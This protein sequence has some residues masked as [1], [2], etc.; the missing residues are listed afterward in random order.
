MLPPF[1]LSMSQPKFRTRLVLFIL[2][3]GSIQCHAQVTP[4]P[5]QAPST[6]KMSDLLQQIFRDQDLKTDPNKD[7]QRAREVERQLATNPSLRDEIKLRLTLASFELRAGDSQVAID[8]LLKVRSLAETHG[9]ILAPA[10]KKQI[11][12][13]LAIA[14]MRLGEQENCVHYHGQESCLFPVRGSGVHQLTRGMEGAVRELTDALQE[15]PADLKSRWLLNIAYITLG[16][17]PQ[18]VP[19][20]WLIP[21]GTFDSDYD[22][23]RSKMLLPKPAFSEWAT[24][25]ASSWKTSMATACST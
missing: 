3:L 12:D 10:Y 5:Y 11:R 4:A 22:I 23:D 1:N 19:A 14:Y 8:Q 7:A 13:L 24:P 9:V 21:A 2:L 17:Y 20:R 25:A 6:R 16:R 15:N 18:D